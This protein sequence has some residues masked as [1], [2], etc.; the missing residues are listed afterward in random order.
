MV[1]VAIEYEIIYCIQ[2]IQVVFSFRII[3]ATLFILDNS[4]KVYEKVEF[5]TYEG[6]K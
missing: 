5:G 6:K 4:K 2:Y 1:N 3:I